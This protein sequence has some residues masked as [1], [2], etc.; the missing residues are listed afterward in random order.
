MKCQIFLLR[1]SVVVV[2][3]LDDCRAFL[4]KYPQQINQ[5]IKGAFLSVN[6]NF[7][8]KLSILKMDRGM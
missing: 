3:R 4:I 2:P 7:C 5:R 6:G 8:R 1:G